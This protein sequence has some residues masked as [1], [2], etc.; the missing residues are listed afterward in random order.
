[1]GSEGCPTPTR[2]SGAIAVRVVAVVSWVFGLLGGTENYETAAP[3]APEARLRPID[4]TTGNMASEFLGD[5]ASRSGQRRRPLIIAT[6]LRAAGA[7]GVQ[8]HVREVTSYFA[9]RGNEPQVVTPMSWGGPLAVPAFA[10]RLVLDQI[11][12]TAGVVWYRFWHF[13]FLR[14]ALRKKLPG[15]A[16]DA[17]IYA[18]CPLSARAALETR[19]PSQQVV[20]AVH[21]GSSQADEWVDAGKIRRGG[22]VYRAIRETEKR[23][24]PKVERIV[25]VSSASKLELEHYVPAVAAVPAAVIPNFISLHRDKESSSDT[26]L[27]ADLVNVGGLLR[28]KNHK[29]LL[30]VLAHANRLGRRYT[31]DIIGDGPMASSLVDLARS[32]GVEDQVRFLGRRDDVQHLLPRH[33]VYVHASTRESLCIAIIEAMGAGLPIVASP[34]NGIMELFKPGVEGYVWGLEDP[35]T[36]TQILIGL[37]EDSARLASMSKA[38]RERFHRDFDSTV[39]GPVIERFL[40]TDSSDATGDRSTTPSKEHRE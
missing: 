10:P 22:L 7:T 26:E 15:L 37:L 13:R 35:E 27:S 12:G 1:M 25:Y 6:M 28:I 30:E 19:R 20:A 11:S 29:F 5:Q 36:A 3:F 23:V 31:L 17:V 9:T 40:M 21:F 18:Q 34:T 32:L 8:T 39:V 38:A 2:S 14:R 16:E 24:L 4:V 33:R